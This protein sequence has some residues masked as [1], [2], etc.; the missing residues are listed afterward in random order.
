VLA[1]DFSLD[2]VEFLLCRELASIGRRNPFLNLRN[3]G[4]LVRH[5]TLDGSPH[6]KIARAVRIRSERVKLRHSRFLELYRYP[7]AHLNLSRTT[8]PV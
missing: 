5:E 4:R 6:Q 1:C 2:L 8:V 3:E 7:H